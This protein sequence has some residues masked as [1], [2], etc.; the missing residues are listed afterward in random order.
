MRCGKGCTE[1]DGGGW[2][3]TA[4]RLWLSRQAQGFRNRL[5]ARPVL[6]MCSCFNCLKFRTRFNFNKL[7]V[8]Y[9]ICFEKL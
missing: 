2:S 5:V 1:L 8:R 6:A 7:N 4:G 3:L 9:T